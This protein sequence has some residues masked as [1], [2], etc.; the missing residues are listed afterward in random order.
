MPEMRAALTV[1]SLG[2]NTRFSTKTDSMADDAELT[3]LSPHY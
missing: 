3:G 1:A 2:L